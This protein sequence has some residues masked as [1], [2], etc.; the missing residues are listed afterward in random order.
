MAPHRS[1]PPTLLSLPSELQTQIALELACGDGSPGPPSSL[2]CFL[3]TH[4]SVNHHLHFDSNPSFYSSILHRTWDTAAAERRFGTGG[5]LRKEA[6]V[7][8]K[9]L[10]KRIKN[11]A[12]KLVDWAKA[13]EMEREK[14]GRDMLAVWLLLTENDGR[15]LS[16]LLLWA[17][18]PN[19][20]LEYHRGVILPSSLLPPPFPEETLDVAMHVLL[21]TWLDELGYELRC[22]ILDAAGD[23]ASSTHVPDQPLD[24]VEEKLFVL[25]PFAL[26]PFK[27]QST[28]A[29]W[30]L[31]TISSQSGK[32]REL[33]SVVEGQDTLPALDITR[34]GRDWR[35]RAPLLSSSAIPGLLNQL[36]RTPSILSSPDDPPSSSNSSTYSI[37]FLYTG[38]D[39]PI[40]PP[41]P[42][43]YDKDHGS[44]LR[45]SIPR[46]QLHSRFHDLDV[47]R[48]LGCT[49]PS[50]DS[51]LGPFG[52]VR[53]KLEGVW[54]GSYSFFDFT[55]YREMLGGESG[56]LH[57]GGVGQQAQ[58]IQLSETVVRV[59]ISFLG[60]SGSTLNAGYPTSN[61]APD[62]YAMCYSTEE[63]D[64][65]EE[66]GSGFAKELLLTGWGRGKWGE[67][68]FYGRVRAYDGMITLVK[69]YTANALHK[70][71]WIYR[72]Y[73]HQ[74][75]RLVGVWR[76]TFSELGTQGYESGFSARKQSPEFLV[77]TQRIPDEDEVAR[78]PLLSPPSLALPSPPL[79]IKDGKPVFFGETC[80]VEYKERTTEYVESS[81]CGS[82][83][84][85]KDAPDN[86]S[87]TATPS[88]SIPTSTSSS[89]TTSSSSSS[90]IGGS[91]KKHIEM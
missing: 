74:D 70:S 82:T 5:A 16:Q 13:G 6:R 35:I 18:L 57:E 71:K 61:E 81:K 37:T 21:G 41:P 29:S 84:P 36:D 68:R 33:S 65:E 39:T 38:F 23:D 72:G 28:L 25:R 51:K 83:D 90:E 69:E 34:F 55:A 48:A 2:L 64:L 30:D 31:K 42:V 10:K 86:P 73:L 60:G 88:S 80:P 56:R 32:E 67:C 24:Q 1:L 50:T 52:G 3:L 89:S 58:E 27:Y 7:G 14:A 87:E 12:S 26:A 47:R 59:P 44:L 17:D 4:P 75:S 91:A 76:D 45:R 79:A 22:S 11:G 54:H 53:G 40:P 78:P 15:N 77:P 63:E 20:V 43:Y 46:I 66:E 8:A 49:D 19:Y 9:E 62:P 85:S